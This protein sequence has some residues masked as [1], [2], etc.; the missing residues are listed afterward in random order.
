MKRIDQ[1]DALVIF[2]FLGRVGHLIRTVR[3]AEH[4]VSNLRFETGAVGDCNTAPALDAI[5]TSYLGA[6][7]QGSQFF[8]QFK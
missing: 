6:P 5:M 3:T 2:V 1:V 4:D 7:R 8:Q